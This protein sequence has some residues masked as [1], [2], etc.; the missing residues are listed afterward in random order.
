MTATLQDIKG[1]LKEG[2]E[3][4]ATHVIIAC[5]S[6]DHTNYPVFVMEGEDPHERA[7]KLGNM[8]HVDECYAL[9]LDITEQLA[10]RRAHHYEKKEDE[11]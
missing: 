1:W 5:D 6:W 7:A 2:Q 10:E 8:Q 4:G 3:Q 11:K 9:H